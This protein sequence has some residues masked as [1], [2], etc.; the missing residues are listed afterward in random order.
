MYRK[1]WLGA[2]L[3]LSLSSGL[4]ADGQA[5]PDSHAPAGVMGSHMHEQGEVMLGYRYT[6]TF[7]GDYYRGS[8][9]VDSQELAMQGYTMMAG[10]MAME[11]HMLDLMY[12]PR[13]YLT[14]MLMPHYMSMDMS[15]L[16]T[17]TMAPG[18]GPHGH[19]HSVSGFGDTQLS[20]MFQLYQNGRHQL[21][22]APG[23][24]L[25]TGSVS[26]KN[27]NGTLVH[28]EMQLGSG[29]W[30]FMPALTYTGGEALFTWGAQLNA[31]MRLERYN[32][33]GYALGDRM[34]ATAWGA[35]R[36]TEWASLSLRLS[37]EYQSSISGKYNAPHNLTTP[38]DIQANYGGRHMDLGLGLNT[39]I[40]TGGL[41]GLRFELEWLT[42]VAQDY[43]GYQLG[44]DRQL[45]FNIS[46]AFH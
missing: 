35:R 13:D 28:Y 17:M 8:N 9:T 7:S 1:V 3:G 42:R 21:I 12:A 11:M 32:D 18:E 39:V 15:M 33:S 46:Y 36:L 2:V 19:S 10:S 40:P 44:L 31:R 4:Y 22:V 29:T 6:R 5:V 20:A 45:N 25:P 34:Q 37:H 30:D 23:L 27:P 26:L 14:F 24:S 41:A 43:N 38:A 16:P